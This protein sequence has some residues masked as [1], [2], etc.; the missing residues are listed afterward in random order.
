V[1]EPHYETV[2]VLLATLEQT[3]RADFTPQ[4]AEAANQHVIHQEMQVPRRG[5]GLACRVGDV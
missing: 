2:A 4:V 3:L 5:N 1:R